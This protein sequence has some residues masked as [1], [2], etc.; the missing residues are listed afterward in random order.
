MVRFIILFLLVVLQQELYSQV[1]S[2]GPVIT[3]FGKVWDIDKPDYPTDTTLVFKAVFD[4]MNSPEAPDQLNP[5][6]E[7]V[8]RYLNM[9]AQSGVPV[10]QIKAVIVV[11][12]KASKDIML[13]EAYRLKYGVDNPNYQLLK[14]L[15]NAGVQMIFCGQSSLSRDIPKE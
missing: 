6:I 5:W 12:N 8:A 1:K 14:E 13:P 11:H 4:I 3:D 9:H 7:T 2:S 10:D 15:H